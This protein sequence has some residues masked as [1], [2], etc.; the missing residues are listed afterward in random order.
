MPGGGSLQPPVQPIRLDLHQGQRSHQDRHGNSRDVTL[1]HTICTQ[2]HHA[3]FL[4]TDQPPVPD[5]VCVNPEEEAVTQQEEAPR[6]Q[7]AFKR[8]SAGAVSEG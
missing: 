5:G 7:R 4:G 1:I 3:C 6:F 2:E 8:D